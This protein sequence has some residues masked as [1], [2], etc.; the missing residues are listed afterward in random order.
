M[1]MKSKMNKETVKRLMAYSAAA[2]MGAFAFGQAAD[3]AIVV[4]D[5]GAGV[6]VDGGI[7]GAANHDIDFDGD[8]FPDASIIHGFNNIQVRAFGFDELVPGNWATFNQ[9]LTDFAPNAYGFSY[10]VNGMAAGGLVDS[11]GTKG[12]FGQYPHFGY[13]LA[14]SAAYNFAGGYGDPGSVGTF[15]RVQFEIG[16][17]PTEVD[18]VGPD[19]LAGSTTHFGWIELANTTKANGASAVLTRFAYETQANT[20]ILTGAVPEPTSLALLAIGAGG[21]A[22]RRRR[23]A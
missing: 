21:L 3:A 20:P 22:M 2:G 15:F 8:G 19:R 5:L 1:I 12:G 4:T 16:N 6:L 7:N 14:I 9:V 10:Y 11:T 18:G 13:D 23:S 17:D